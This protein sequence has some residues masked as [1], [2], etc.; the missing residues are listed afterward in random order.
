MDE[1]QLQLDSISNLL[2]MHIQQN[3]EKFAEYDKVLSNLKIGDTQMAGAEEAARQVQVN[4]TQ[5]VA[6]AQAQQQQQAQFNNLSSLLLDAVQ[7]I[8]ATNQAINIGAGTQTANPLN[9]NTNVRT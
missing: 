7:N 1:L 4:V 5:S 8:R 9:T 3:A 6:Q 2:A